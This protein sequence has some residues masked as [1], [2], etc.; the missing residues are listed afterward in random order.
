MTRICRDPDCTKPASRGAFMCDEHLATKR[1]CVG[2][3][4][5]YDD[6]GNVV[7]ERRCKK[8]ARA[9][10]DVC[11]SHGGD[12]PRL[13]AASQRTAALT[14][15]QRFVQPYDGPIDAVTGFEREVRR[16]MGR[17]K[18]LEEQI[19]N[20][21]D[22]QDL[23]WGLTK[24]E[25]IDAAEYAGTNRTYEARVHIFEEM[26]WRE[27]KH[28]HELLKTWIR[29]NLDER[30]LTLMQANIDYT[31]A[32]VMN[33]ARMLGHDTAD[34][35]VRHIIGRLFERE[36]QALPPADHEDER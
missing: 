8:A 5:T 30:K 15:M 36:L 25:A 12:G 19:A 2:M 35:T 7:S 10:L 17:I 33:A 13:S 14:A 28:Y 18:W 32:L 6:A 27:R 3:V 31:Y 24:E 23:I 11:N 34:P 9:G 4:K 21:E 22:E 26:L 16:T 1:R 20:L 29:A